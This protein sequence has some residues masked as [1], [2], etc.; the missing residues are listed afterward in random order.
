VV[1]RGG[2]RGEKQVELY[3]IKN[4]VGIERQRCTDE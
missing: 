3:V 2:F 4:T 1:A